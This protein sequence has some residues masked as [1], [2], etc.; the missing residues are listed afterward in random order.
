VSIEANRNLVVTRSRKSIIDSVN[1]VSVILNINELGRELTVGSSDDTL[2]LLTTNSFEVVRL[3]LGSNGKREFLKE[4]ELEGSTLLDVDS[5]W[6]VGN[7]VVLQ[8]DVDSVFSSINRLIGDS[9]GTVV[10]INNLCRNVAGW[11]LDLNL[12]WITSFT[13]I[14]SEPVS[15]FDVED[16]GFGIVDI[17]ETRS[18]DERVGS[19]SSGNN[20]NKVRTIF[21]VV[22][23]ERLLGV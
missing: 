7:S 15:R 5:V 16:S 9:V 11:S 2:E 22:V 17:F 21:D 12:E 20:V 4:C 10:V 19:V 8:V 13:H 3:G 23:V 18:P 6:A 1:T 14:I